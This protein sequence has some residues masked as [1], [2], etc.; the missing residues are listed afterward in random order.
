[1]LQ[2][3]GIDFNKDHRHMQKS[4]R[5]TWTSHFESRAQTPRLLTGLQ[6]CDQFSVLDDVDTSLMKFSLGSVRQIKLAL[7]ALER[8]PPK[9]PILCRVGR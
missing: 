4:A 9:W 5:C 2:P 1:M 8:T 3:A 7:L 6:T